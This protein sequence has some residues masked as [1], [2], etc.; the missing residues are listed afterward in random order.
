MNINRKKAETINAFVDTGL[1]SK[2]QLLVGITKGTI[3]RIKEWH[4]SHRDNKDSKPSL[5]HLLEEYNN[6][7]K[8][9]E[10]LSKM[11][12]SR[13]DV[14]KIANNLLEDIDRITALANTNKIGRNDTCPCGSGKKYK[15]C[16][17]VYA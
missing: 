5:E 4:K 7:P 8:F 16:C 9:R 10:A 13:E 3:K 2:E 11:G 15:R 6:Y 12:I 17:I 1:I 14:E